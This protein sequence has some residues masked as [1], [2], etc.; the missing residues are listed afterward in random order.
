MEKKSGNFKNIEQKIIIRL[1]HN[2]AMKQLGY[3]LDWYD[4]NTQEIIYD[5]KLKKENKNEPYKKM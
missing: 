4:L 1:H 3:P 5:K 2:I